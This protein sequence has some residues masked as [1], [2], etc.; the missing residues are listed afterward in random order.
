MSLQIAI[1]GIEGSYHEIAARK[2]CNDQEIEIIECPNF[3]DVVETVKRN[4]TVLGILAIENTIAGSL[5]LNHELIRKSQLTVIGEYKLRIS[6]CLAS[7]PGTKLSDVQWVASHP[8]ALRQCD[9]FL[10][11]RLPKVG[12]I[13]RN[14]TASS[15]RWIS[16]E[17]LADH[18]AICS[19]EAA[20]NNNLEILVEGIETNSRNFTR[21]LVVA[22]KET[23]KLF[24]NDNQQN[25][26][27][28]VF[29]LPHSVGSLSKV[30]T[31]LSFYE[32]NLTKIQS[33][34]VVGAEWQY[35]FYV[36]FTFSDYFVY[37]RAIDAVLPLIQDLRILG[38]YQEQGQTV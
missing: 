16:K 27:S 15:A 20:W 14:D 24:L 23:A 22:E 13:E 37:Q 21:F 28:I 11:E 12:V 8:I 32:M 36:D 6:H 7:L 33:F 18:A 4:P 34:P 2:F 1:Q 19:R 9:L 10:D 35:L 5:L 3:T 30:L 29:S 26:A 31:I 38:E 25:K 17:K